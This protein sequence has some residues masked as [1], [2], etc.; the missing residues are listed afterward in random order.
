MR[1][2]AAR[3]RFLRRRILRWYAQHRR[4]LEW[5]KTVDPY[6]ILISEI[7]LQQ[8]QVDRVKIKFP[9]FLRRYPTLRS[10]ASARTSD[11]IK[12]WQGMGY[13]NRAVRLKALA[14]AVVRDFHGEIP[15]D[16]EVLAGLPGIGPYTSHALACFAF[17]RR[18]P[19]IDV[20][21]ERVLSRVFDTGAR[22]AGSDKK[23]R[24]HFLASHVLPRNAAAWNQALMDLGATVCKA[25]NPACA[26]CPIN[27]ACVYRR[28][29]GPNS[30]T[31][32]MPGRAGKP[33]PTHRGIPRRLWRGRIIQALRDHPTLSVAKLGDS[34]IPDFTPGELP[35]LSGLLARLQDD[36]LITVQNRRV[37]LGSE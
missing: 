12:A 7:M 33:E 15:R 6:E 4:E 16:V 36:G 5:R 35:W 9:L 32:S 31:A 18:V 1:I 27:P 30:G 34:I 3:I 28:S 8:T 20:N 24:V 23:S 10:L 19:V 13:N 22:G 14:V 17:G 2:P 25:R 21:I 26:I 37:R 29:H 11:V